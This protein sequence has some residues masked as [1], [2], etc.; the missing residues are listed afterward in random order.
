M[1]W[2]PFVS[3]W[4]TWRGRSLRFDR[5]GVGRWVERKRG[6]RLSREDRGASGGGGGLQM[7]ES[8]TEGEDSGEE[9]AR[10]RVNHLVTLRNI[11][12]PRRKVERGGG[13]R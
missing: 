11:F 6:G 5:E 7:K 13:G 8:V 10:R 2:S 9:G 4:R 12:S 1:S 3:G